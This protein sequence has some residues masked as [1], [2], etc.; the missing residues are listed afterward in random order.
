MHGAHGKRID[1][2]V[3]AGRHK[4]DVRLGRK[5]GKL[6]CNLHAVFFGKIDVDESDGKGRLHLCR[7]KKGCAVRKTFGAA[8]R[9]PAAK[10]FFQR[11]RL[12]PVVIQY[13]DPHDLLRK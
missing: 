5:D 6:F 11:F 8:R 12:L 2:A 10:R 9:V 7:R 13:C 3:A 1:G 4:H